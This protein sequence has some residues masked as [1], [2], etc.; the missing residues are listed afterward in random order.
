M[1]D[2]TRKIQNCSS[3]VDDFL[4]IACKLLDWFWK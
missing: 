4:Q 3:G 2:C 1:G